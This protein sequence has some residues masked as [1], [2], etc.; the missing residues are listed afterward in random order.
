[1]APTPNLGL[2]D[3]ITEHG[4]IAIPIT[5]GGKMLTSAGREIGNMYPSVRF[6]LKRKHFY[7]MG[8][9]APFRP[10][11]KNSLVI[12]CIVCLISKENEACTVCD[13]SFDI[14]IR[15][16]R[17]FSY[18]MDKPCHIRQD[19]LGKSRSEQV[20]KS[21]DINFPGCKVWVS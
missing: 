3:K 8:S 19:C 12:V 14:G 4:I 10:A 18:M 21:T 20:I 16:L 1:M 13:S 11:N 7:E 9:I 6:E 17:D 15:N 2:F 5:S